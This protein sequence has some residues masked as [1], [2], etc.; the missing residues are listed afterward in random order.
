MKKLLFAVAILFGAMFAS[1]GNGGNQ[2]NGEMT[3]DS[4]SCDS[5]GLDSSAV[6]LD[7]VGDHSELTVETPDTL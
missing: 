6:V 4:I 2:A 7:T 5:V 3:P 1:C